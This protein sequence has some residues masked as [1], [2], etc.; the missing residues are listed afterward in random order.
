MVVITTL[1]LFS[2]L[3]F[4]VYFST[5]CYRLT[6]CLMYLSSR[7]LVLFSLKILFI[8]LVLLQLR[9]LHSPGYPHLDTLPRIGFNISLQRFIYD[10]VDSVGLHC[11]LFVV[12]PLAGAEANC[13]MVLGNTSSLSC[14]FFM[15]WELVSSAS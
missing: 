5:K 6:A 10:S 11:T 1:T 15:N 13:H 2:V 7:L 9:A 3:C 4:S 12:W 14:C 8:A